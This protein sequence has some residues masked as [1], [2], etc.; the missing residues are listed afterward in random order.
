MTYLDADR[1]AIYLGE[2]GKPAVLK[3]P[4]GDVIA[5][6]VTLLLLKDQRALKTLEATGEMYAKFEGGRETI[7]DRLV[8]DAVSETH[9]ITGKPMYF[10]NIQMDSGKN[11][12]SLE[13]S[14]ELHY[15]GKGQTIDEPGS[16]PKSLTSV[17]MP[18][19]TPIKTFVQT[20]VP[21][22]P[23]SNGDA[24]HR[25]T[26]QVVQRPHGRPQREPR[27]VVRRSRRPARARTAPARRPR[28]AWSS[29]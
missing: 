15:E 29:G 20:S 3:G 4:D 9:V 24:A 22:P 11:S 13:K 25:R 6:Q 28:S 2:A 10:K 7:G 26:D 12:C 27:C 16:A 23:S 19:A 8:Y 1:Q 5:H 18:C 14:T 21:R 17:Q